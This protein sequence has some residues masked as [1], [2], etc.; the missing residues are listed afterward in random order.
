MYAREIYSARKT[1]IGGFIIAVIIILAA[2]IVYML[3]PPTTIGEA[4][5]IKNATLCYECHE[6]PVP[7][8][9][10]AMPHD[11]PEGGVD[12][13]AHIEAGVKCLACHDLV[14]PHVEL[15]SEEIYAKCS[16]CH[17][18]ID[19]LFHEVY[20][21]KVVNCTTCHGG[22]KPDRKTVPTG[23]KP[24]FACEYCHDREFITEHTETKDWHTPHYKLMN[25]STCHTGTKHSTWL[26]PKLN[27]NLCKT[28]HESVGLHEIHFVKVG[29]A[30]EKCHEDSKGVSWFRSVEGSSTCLNCHPINTLKLH[31]LLNLNT[32]YCLQC[33]GQ[34]HSEYIRYTGETCNVCHG[35][36]F[37]LML[38]PYGLHVPHVKWLGNCTVCHE[39]MTHTEWI[40]HPKSPTY[41][42]NCHTA[43]GETIGVKKIE[44]PPWHEQ[45]V[46]AHKGDC[47]D[48]HTYGYWRSP[49]LREYGEILS[50]IIPILGLPIAIVMRR[51]YRK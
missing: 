45:A 26:E 33:H 50:I 42:L 31:D 6:E 39:G 43:K 24:E 51:K 44:L 21:D 32:T 14:R 23:V 48:C 20:S 8:T 28:C 18:P 37:K 36:S 4:Y 9:R 15:S 40:E 47:F 10:N 5:T 30:C 19:T 22:W 1:F 27:V 38:V 49:A 17:K 13:V 25:C 2:G 16:T 41:C 11:L 3:T 34:W 35:D 12:H 46:E 7:Q 29:I